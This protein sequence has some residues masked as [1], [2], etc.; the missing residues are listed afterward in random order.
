MRDEKGHYHSV[1]A[2]SDNGPEWAAGCDSCK[3]GI[4]LAPELTGACELYLERLVQAIA[5]DVT[6]CACQAGVRARANLLNRRQ[7]LIGEAR[8]DPRMSEQAQ[9]LSHPDIDI[10][11][12]AVRKTQATNVPTVHADGQP[13]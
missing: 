13:V 3:Y 11:A 4:V 12:H 2:I 7:R 9:R 5:G 1:K 10:S 8:K 6:F